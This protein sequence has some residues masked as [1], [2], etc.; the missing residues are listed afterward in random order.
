MGFRCLLVPTEHPEVAEV[1][2]NCGGLQYNILMILKR[3]LA[4]TAVSTLRTKIRI[5]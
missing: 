1:E 4:P 3:D 5:Y 2:V